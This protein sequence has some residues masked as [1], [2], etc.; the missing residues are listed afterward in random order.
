MAIAAFSLP[1]GSRLMDFKDH[2]WTTKFSANPRI[3]FQSKPHNLVQRVYAATMAAI[4]M[5][6]LRLLTKY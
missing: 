5:S 4:R 3:V 2:Q 6:L 1:G